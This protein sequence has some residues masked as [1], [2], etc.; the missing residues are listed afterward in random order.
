MNSAIH[1]TWTRGGKDLYSAKISDLHIVELKLVLEGG[2]ML[3]ER[4]ECRRAGDMVGEC[5]DNRYF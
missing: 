1:G 2:D 5:M 3:R 4:F